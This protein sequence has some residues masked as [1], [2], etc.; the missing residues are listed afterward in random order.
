MHRLMLAKAESKKLAKAP[1]ILRKLADKSE[2]VCRLTDYFAGMHAIFQIG[3]KVYPLTPELI[4]DSQ[5]I[6][7]RS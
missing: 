7:T 5:A 4:L 6:R 2:I 3:I 1:N